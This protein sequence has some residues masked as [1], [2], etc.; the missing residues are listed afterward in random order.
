MANRTNYEIADPKLPHCDL[1][2]FTLTR[3]VSVADPHSPLLAIALFTCLGVIIP[4]GEH[5]TPS[6]EQ[7]TGKRH[8]LY[9]G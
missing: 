3:M 8:L 6:A 4:L 9:V 1:H 5:V 2:F 7:R